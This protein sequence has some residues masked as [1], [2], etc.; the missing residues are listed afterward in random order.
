[1]RHFGGDYPAAPAGL[2]LQI[3]RPPQRESFEGE[4]QNLI[5]DGIRAVPLHW[6]PGQQFLLWLASYSAPARRAHCN[7]N[8]NP[9]HHHFLYLYVYTA[10]HMTQQS[11]IIENTQWNVFSGPSLK[12]HSK[13]AKE[14]PHSQIYFLYR[15][16][17]FLH[18][19][20]SKRTFGFVVS[21]IH[22]L[23]LKE[24]IKINFIR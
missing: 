10:A 24:H 17:H 4:R 5:A 11:S 18:V 14:K 16:E 21:N 9:P 20:Y 7:A 15:D 2:S 23:N 8:N 12:K 1:M 6:A 13:L 22:R 19:G 3:K